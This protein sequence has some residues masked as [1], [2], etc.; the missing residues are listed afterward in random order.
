[1]TVSIQFFRNYPSISIIR[2]IICIEKTKTEILL[3]K[4]WPLGG[5]YHQVLKTKDISSLT[6]T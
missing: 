1:M 5:N 6:V 3:G 2:N 4:K